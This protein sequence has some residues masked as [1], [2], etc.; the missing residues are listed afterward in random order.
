MNKTDDKDDRNDKIDDV[1]AMI[2]IVERLKSYE[3]KTAV[4][5]GSPVV[6]RLDGRGFSGFTR[7]LEKPF[8]ENFVKCML[9]TVKHLVHATHATIGYVQSDEISLFY[10]NIQP[11]LPE[12]TSTLMFNGRLEKLASVYAGMASSKF[13]FEVM[14]HLPH[15]L[16]ALPSFDARVIVL[17]SY[18]EAWECLKWRYVDAKR[19]SV[20]MVAHKFHRYINTLSGIGTKGRIKLLKETYNIDWMDYST[21]NREG[22]WL[23]HITRECE[24]TPEDRKSVV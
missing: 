1:D 14:K 5:S 11:I 9:E 12:Q 7:N 8:D 4:P 6:I 18:D 10:P 13:M 21:H 20:S 24:L 16:E 2:T 22:T 15:K 17:P 19:N 23:K 3:D